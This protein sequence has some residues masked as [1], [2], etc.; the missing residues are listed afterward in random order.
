MPV[1]IRG[2]SADCVFPIGTDE[3]RGLIR[4]GLSRPGVVPISRVDPAKTVFL[5]TGELE[6]PFAIGVGG[7]S[8]ILSYNFRP[9]LGV[10]LLA[11]LRHICLPF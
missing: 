2:F 6:G 4:R 11:Q 5:R 3:I 7:Q 1:V 9:F 10:I 8:G